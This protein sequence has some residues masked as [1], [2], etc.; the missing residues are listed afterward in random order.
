VIRAVI[1]PDYVS[2]SFTGFLAI[3]SKIVSN[4]ELKVVASQLV[5][6]PDSTQVRPKKANRRK[7]VR[8]AD[9]AVS[10]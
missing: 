10:G 1:R 2:A 6:N 4:P 8:M 9:Y 3:N 7:V 5:K